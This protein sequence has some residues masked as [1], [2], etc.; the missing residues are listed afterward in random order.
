[1]FPPQ[2]KG[3]QTSGEIAS[4]K[5]GEFH[6]HPDTEDVQTL[7]SS[8]LPR[9][10]RMTAMPRRP[11]SSASQKPRKQTSSGKEPPR[12]RSP[13]ARDPT[14]TQHHGLGRLHVIPG[15]E[16]QD[17]ASAETDN[18]HRHSQGEGRNPG[19]GLEGYGATPLNP[20][21]R[22]VPPP[23][24]SEPPTARGLTQPLPPAASRARPHP[25]PSTNCREE[26]VS[27]GG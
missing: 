27:K 3:I 22:S 1:M 25:L 16:N 4:G 12:G 13:L 11:G 24:L 14:E 21:K 26:Q 9:P 5:P 6:T 10:A 15:P 18:D 8:P 19:G 2:K 17:Q 7:T 23:L 20:V